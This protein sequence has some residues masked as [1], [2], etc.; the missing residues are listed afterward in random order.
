MPNT[1]THD[2]LTV[3]SS[4]VMTPALFSM[5]RVS[6]VAQPSAVIVASVVCVAH[7]VSGLLF[8]PD[9]DLDSR[10]HQRWG[11]LLFI[12]KPYKWVIPHRHFW[13]HGLV[14]PPILRLVYFF[15]MMLGLLFVIESMVRYTGLPLPTWHATI[16]KQCMDWFVAHPIITLSM[17]VGFITGGAV[18]SIADWIV[19]GGKKLLRVLFSSRTRPAYTRKSNPWSGVHTRWLF[20]PFSDDHPRHY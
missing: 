7:N 2:F 10:I 8:S 4:V 14:L 1:P 11:I 13:S 15:M 5:M 18:H 12:W 6:E 19:T 9:L 16:A 3:A 20:D 17:V